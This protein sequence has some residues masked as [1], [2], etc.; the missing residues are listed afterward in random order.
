MNRRSSVVTMVDEGS[1]S[2]SVACIGNEASFDIDPQPIRKS[3]FFLTSLT[4]S[5]MSTSNLNYLS[6]DH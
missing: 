3:L 4:S 6:Q 5:S 1:I 2:G